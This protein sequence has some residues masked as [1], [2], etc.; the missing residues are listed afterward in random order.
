[1]KKLRIALL[2][3]CTI[4]FYT[5]HKAQV[6]G[7]KAG[8]SISDLVGELSTK[9]RFDVSAGFY[10][11]LD[12]NDRLSFQVEAIF[13]RQGATSEVDDQKIRL[14]YFAIPILVK[15]ELVKQISV[16]AGPQ[17]SFITTAQTII[18]GEVIN[19]ENSVNNADFG[20]VGGFAYEFPSG[21]SFDFRFHQGFVKAYKNTFIDPLLKNQVIHVSIGY[22]LVQ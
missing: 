19:I 7:F 8:L 13:N 4:I 17:L 20:L 6:L 9:S 14:H 15:Y 2:L 1:M 18:E 16:Y 11:D 22:L 5:E 3:I 21:L 10:A 12:F